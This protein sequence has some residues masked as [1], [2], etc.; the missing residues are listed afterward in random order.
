MTLDTFGS[1]FFRGLIPLGLVVG[2]IWFPASPA[3]AATATAT[4]AVTA[5]VVATCT[6]SATPL[7]FG[8]YTGT[9][10]DAASAVT[11]TC[12]NTTPWTITLDPGVATGATVTARKMTGPAAALLAYSLYTD[13]GRTTNWGNTVAPNVVSGTG[14]GSAQSNPVYGRI[15]AGLFVAPGGYTDTITATVTY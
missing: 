12:T 13:A 15:A 1:K 10:T 5:T 9:Q 14:S 3:M 7:A 11:V 8:N 6:T 2:T 4:F